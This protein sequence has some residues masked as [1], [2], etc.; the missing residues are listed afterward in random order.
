MFVGNDE[1]GQGGSSSQMT[2]GETHLLL[3]LDPNPVFD[4][5]DISLPGNILK[6]DVRICTGWNLRFD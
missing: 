3:L 4:D 1:S 6:N 2:D 5:K